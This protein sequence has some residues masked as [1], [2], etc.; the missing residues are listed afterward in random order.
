MKNILFFTIIFLTTFT[1]NVLSD[2]IKKSGFLDTKT[3]IIKSEEIS[4]PKNKI[5]IIYNHGQDSL[6]RKGKNCTWIG[7][8][9]NKASLVGNEINGKKIMVYNLCTN[10]LVG[11]EGSDWWGSGKIYSG[12][13]KL[14]KRVQANLEL[15]E[16]FVAKGVPRK[17]IF[18]SGHSCGGL[19]TLLFFSRY[20]DKAGGGI[21]YMQAC[22][23][24]LSHAYKVKKV[25]VEKALEKFKKKYPGPYELRERQLEEI[26]N[27]LKVPLLAFTH[28][29]DKY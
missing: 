8:L 11:D 1:T 29:K 17:Q 25:G 20:P 12:K 7:S 4:D 3:K 28:P 2:A 19:T 27:K 5:I 10:K 14:D 6:D 24:K 15:V 16:K 21:S 23:G 26:K 13:T 22:F 9:R 18:I